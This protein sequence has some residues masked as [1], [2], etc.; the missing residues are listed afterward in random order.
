MKKELEFENT[1][2][3]FITANKTLEQEYIPDWLP[4]DELLTNV[5]EIKY[6]SRKRTE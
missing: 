4:Q 1:E 3:D 6:V 2:A 5:N